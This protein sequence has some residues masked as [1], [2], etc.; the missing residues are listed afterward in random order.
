MRMRGHVVHQETEV[1]GGQQTSQA[2][3]PRGTLPRDPCL[4][5]HHCIILRSCMAP[6]EQEQAQEQA[7]RWARSL[8]QGQ[9]EPRGRFARREVIDRVRWPIILADYLESRDYSTVLGLV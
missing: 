5:N 6:Q 1:T 8:R 2:L 7:F 3:P 4:R 9:G